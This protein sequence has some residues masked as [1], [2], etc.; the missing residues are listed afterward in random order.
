[1]FRRYVECSPSRRVYVPLH[2]ECVVGE[3][4]AS[5]RGDAGATMSIEHVDVV[6][7]AGRKN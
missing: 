5:A 7:S 2:V 6:G 4:D 3:V 1:M